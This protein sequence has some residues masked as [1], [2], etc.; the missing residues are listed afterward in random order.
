MNTMPQSL[1][2]SG[3]L[4]PPA[5]ENFDSVSWAYCYAHDPNEDGALVRGYSGGRW[6][7]FAVDEVA[8]T[9]GT[10]TTTYVV[11]SRADGS[12]SFSTSTTNWNN[13][14]D[15][16]RIESVVTNGSQITGVTDYRGGAGGVHGS[17]G[18]PPG[19][20]DVYFAVAA[21]DEETPLTTGTAKITFHW[22]LTGTL[23]EVWAGLSTPQASG[24][25]LTVDVNDAGSTML[26]TKITIDN[27]EDTSLTAATPPVLSDTSVTK[28]GK[29]T[30][31]IDQIGDGT[32]CGLKVYFRIT[33]P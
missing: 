2:S 22:P 29:A 7:G 33:P 13:P 23:A 28:G 18:V 27:T 3:D 14:A 9:F 16:V 26:S 1:P 21:S 6:S 20:S 5:N 19:V 30:I 12:I 10:S 24:S 8:H 15:Y 11:A 17:S 31:D 4:R 32:A 25:T